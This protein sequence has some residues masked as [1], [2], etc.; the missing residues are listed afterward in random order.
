[1]TQARAAGR[2]ALIL[3]VAPAGASTQT[4]LSVSRQRDGGSGIGVKAVADAGPSPE[5]VRV[6]NGTVRGMG[7]H[8]V[9]LIGN[10]TVVERVHAISNGGPGLVVGLGSIIDSVAMFNGAGSAVVVLMLSADV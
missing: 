9:R 7:G 6:M 1:M 8:G 5:N 10:G 4:G 2:V 3:F